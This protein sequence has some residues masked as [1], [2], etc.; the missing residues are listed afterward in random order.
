M[1]DGGPEDNATDISVRVDTY[2]AL[3]SVQLQPRLYT[4][5]KKRECEM[6]MG[7]NRKEERGEEM[8]GSGEIKRD[9]QRK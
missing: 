3:D 8:R 2:S 4:G 5:T 1:D 9:M 6:R 7:V